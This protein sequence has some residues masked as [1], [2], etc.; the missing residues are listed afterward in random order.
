MK[1]FGACSF[2][3]GEID[4]CAPLLF[5]KKF[6]TQ[7]LLFETFFDIMYIFGS[8]EPKSKSTFHFSTLYFKNGNLSRPL[9]PLLVEI[10]ICTY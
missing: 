4:T 3:L 6:S 8:I 10:D 5:C 1:I 7:Q 2:T 9:A